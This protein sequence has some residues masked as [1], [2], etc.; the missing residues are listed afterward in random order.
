MFRA[1]TVKNIEVYG[2]IISADTTVV[3]RKLE[4]GTM[5]ATYCMM[6]FDIAPDEYVKLTDVLSNFTH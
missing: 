6:T 2:R 4:D 1:L 3:I 5:A